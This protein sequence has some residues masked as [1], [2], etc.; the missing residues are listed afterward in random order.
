M[1]RL[2]AGVP[3]VVSM[4]GYKR[5][6]RS[7]FRVDTNDVHIAKKELPRLV[8]ESGLTL[9]KYELASQSLE[10]VFVELMTNPEAKH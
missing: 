5:G 7:V 4:D 3:W 1:A 2:L 8:Y 9:L 10:D 6:E